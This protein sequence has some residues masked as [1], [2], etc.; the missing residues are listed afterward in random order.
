M[1]HNKKKAMTVKKR[2]RLCSQVSLCKLQ[3]REENVLVDKLACAGYGEA[4]KRPCGRVYL[5]G[6]RQ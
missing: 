5:C 6:L 1:Y 2:Q 4:R 3:Q